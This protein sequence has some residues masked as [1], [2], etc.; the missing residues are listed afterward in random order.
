MIRMYKKKTFNQE[1]LNKIH[2]D[3]DK[4]R[5]VKQIKYPEI[6]FEQDST[7]IYVYLEKAKSDSFD[8]FIGFSNDKG[9]KVAF[10]GYLDLI[11]NNT[12]NSGEQFS[13]LWKSDANLQKTFNIALELPYIFKSPIGLKA[14]LNIFKQD[15]TFQNTKT[16]IDLGYFF[17]YNTRLYLGY[18]ATESSDIQNT[19]TASISDYKNDYVTTSFE[20]FAYRPD[21]FLFPE[22]TRVNIKL[23]YGTRSAKFNTDKQIF[24]TIDLKHNFYLNDKNSINVKSQNFYLQ[25]DHYITNE[26]YRFGGINSIRGFSENSLQGNMLTSILI[27]YRYALTPSIY[28]HTIIDYGYYQDKSTNNKGTLLGLGIGFGLLTKNGLLNI[29]YANGSNKDSAIK[30]SNSIVHLSFKTN[31]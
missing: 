31:F 21:D 16:A 3:F 15:S 23:G 6:L 12:L 10:N 20:Y 26:L 11:L 19:N 8:G 5:F 9:G 24:T 17:N 25:S 1:N 22:K 2:S 7:K 18:Q 30:L 13:L 14:Q 28:T 27:E 29:V 4:F